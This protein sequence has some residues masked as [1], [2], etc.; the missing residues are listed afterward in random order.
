MGRGT[1]AYYLV[2]ILHINHRA[3]ERNFELSNM[4]CLGRDSNRHPQ[5]L[6]AST[7]TATPQSPL[8]SALYT[9]SVSKQ[10]PISQHQRWE[11]SVVY[12]PLKEVWYFNWF[13]TEWSRL[14][15]IRTATLKSIKL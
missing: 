11:V 2:K 4:K 3:L 7:L 9:A 10:L 15:E 6:K 1:S 8:D 5:R 13:L 12:S 14:I